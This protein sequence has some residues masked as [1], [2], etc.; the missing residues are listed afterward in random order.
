MG[1][2][3]EDLKIEGVENVG[4]LVRAGFTE[5]ATLGDVRVAREG[6]LLMFAYT[7]AAQ[8]AG[9]WNAFERMSRGLILDATTGEVVARP[10]DKFYNW[11][12][13]GRTSDTTFDYVMEKVDGSLII[14]FH[15]GGRWRAATRGSFTSD[16]K[17]LML[18][19]AMSATGNSTTRMNTTSD[20]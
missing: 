8:Y 2:V 17:R 19:R 1:N 5:W 14:C 13:G 20:T 7:P 3:P 12:E 15:H 18:M 11:D 10:F 6:D 9:R 16:Q 4:R